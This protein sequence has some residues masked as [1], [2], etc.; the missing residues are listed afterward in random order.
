[1]KSIQSLCIGLCLFALGSPGFAN[2]GDTEKAEPKPEMSLI[3][4]QS[5][6]Q[7]HRSKALEAAPRASSA[8]E[9]IQLH[10]VSVKF[11]RNWR[12][13]YNLDRN[14]LANHISKQEEDELRQKASKL[15]DEEFSKLV[16]EHSRLAL[17]KDANSKTLIIKPRIVDLVINAPDLKNAD[18]SRHLRVY[19]AGK[20]T[21]LLDVIDGS[22]GE[23]LGTIRS[24]REATEYH[25]LRRASSVFNRSEAKRIIRR[26]AKNLD[27]N[28]TTLLDGTAV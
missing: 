7:I 25:Q 5:R 18:A 6:L 27:R 17:S 24:K 3:V 9:Q 15:F 22:N 28:L 4:D 13:D 16:S 2:D 21:L 23:L 26:W 1:M 12:R 8:F 20:A 11:R 10:P 19:S 14:S